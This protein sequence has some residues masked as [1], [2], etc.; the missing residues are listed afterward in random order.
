MNVFHPD[1]LW[2]LPYLVGSSSLDPHRLPHETRHAE[3]ATM[4]QRQHTSD[5]CHEYTLPTWTWYNLTLLAF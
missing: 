5:K 3:R 1:P 4:A 2:A